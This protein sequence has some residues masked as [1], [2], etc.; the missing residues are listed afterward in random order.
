M[1]AEVTLNMVLP[2]IDYSMENNGWSKL[3]NSIQV[4]L[5]PMV[6]IFLKQ[7]ESQAGLD[8]KL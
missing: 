4:I 7:C 3:L 5:L 2:I 1:P 6:L 8:C